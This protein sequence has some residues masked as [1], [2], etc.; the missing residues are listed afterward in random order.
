MKR[1][2]IVDHELVTMMPKDAERLLKRNHTENRKIREKHVIELCDAMESG[3]FNSEDGQTIVI[4]ENRVLYDGQ[5]R[6]AA[7]VRANIP[8]KWLVVT[9]DDG[10][11]AF[12]TIDSGVK[13]TVADFFTREKNATIFATTSVFAYALNE[14]STPLATA[15]QGNTTT[16]GGSYRPLR[17]LIVA[18]G[19]EHADE[20]RP[21]VEVGVR[22]CNATGHF[23]PKSVYAKF[24]YLMWLLGDDERMGEFVESFCDLG[25][26]NAT[27]QQ[28]RMSIV[29][30]YAKDEKRRPEAAWLIGMLLCAYGH[31]ANDDGST[32]LNSGSRLL[33]VYDAKLAEWRERR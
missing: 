7:Q 20:I 1:T 24:S 25:C 12:K 33:K 15:L 29:R 19:E 6:L 31:F 16:H 32:M 22:M 5:H 8:M 23:G 18:Y 17:H 21:H 10:D 27:V 2:K 30:N 13:R 26:S 3:D 14:T 28:L 11:A 9:V 4:G